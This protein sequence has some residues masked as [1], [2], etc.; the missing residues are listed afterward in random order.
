MDKLSPTQETGIKREGTTIQIPIPNPLQ[1]V[2]AGTQ[3]FL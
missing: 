3:T 2:F 1:N